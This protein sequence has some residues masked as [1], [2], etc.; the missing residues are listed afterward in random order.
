MCRWMAWLGQPLL[1]EELL[2]KT[3][4]GIVDQ[5]LHPGWAPSRPTATASAWAGTATAT[6][7]ASTAASRPRGRTRTCASSPRISSRRCLWRMSGQRS[8]RPCSRPTATRSVTAAGCSSTTATSGDFHELRRDLMM[9]IDPALFADV[10]GSTDT[11]VVFHLA[12]TFGLEHDPIARARADRRLDR[13]GRPRATGVADAG[14]GDL[15]R[16]G[17]REPLGRSLRDGRACRARCS[18]RPTPT[19]SAGCIPRTSASSGSPDDRLI[20]SEPF[21]DLPGLWNEIRPPPR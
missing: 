11:E 8:A 4:H 20:V 19:R 6:G 13:G 15:R 3:Q 21:S 18:R 12:L 16:L 14:A 10:H 1:L 9:S 17:R 7:R 5:S 2:F